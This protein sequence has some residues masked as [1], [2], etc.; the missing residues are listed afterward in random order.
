MTTIVYGTDIAAVDDLPDPDVVVS[1]ELNAAYACARRLMTPDGALA[2]IG[3]TESYSSLD[4]REW[5]G[6]SYD[7][8]D[9]SVLDDLASQCSEVL[10]EEP[11]ALGCSVTVTFARG[12][13]TITSFIGANRT[14]FSLVVASGAAGVTASLLLPGQ[15]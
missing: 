12:A 6:G 9:Q 15:D 10:Q 14:L 5:L 1:E 13:L 3:E 11:F 7:L 8:T 4:V 2:D